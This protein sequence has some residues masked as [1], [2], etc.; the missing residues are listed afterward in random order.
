MLCKNER[1]TSKGRHCV[2]YNNLTI[3]VVYLADKDVGDIVNKLKIKLVKADRIN[4]SDKQFYVRTGGRSMFLVTLKRGKDLHNV[5]CLSHNAPQD[6]TE[7]IE[8]V[9]LEDFNRERLLFLFEKQYT[10]YMK[11][12]N[13][14]IS[15]SA[16]SVDDAEETA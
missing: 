2:F 4:V 8:N 15:D 13:G 14:G 10:R 1:A 5:T 7:A 16:Y 9:I 3:G 11:V 6:A 12:V